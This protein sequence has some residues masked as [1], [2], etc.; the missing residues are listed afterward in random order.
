MHPNSLFVAHFIG[1][2]NF[3]EGYIT[4]T[5]GFSEIELRDGLKIKALNHE[6]KQGERIVLAIR[7]ETCEMK[8]GHIATENGL[9]GKIDKITFEG[10]FVRYEIRLENGDRFSY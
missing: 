6:I 9:F 2:S 1:E 10:T 4:K 7:P 8:T 5:N 3:L